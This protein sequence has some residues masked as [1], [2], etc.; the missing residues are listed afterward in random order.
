MSGLERLLQGLPLALSGV[1]RILEM[2]DW[3]EAAPFVALGQVKQRTLRRSQCSGLFGCH[4]DEWADS[5]LTALSCSVQV[6]ADQVD[7]ETDVFV[8]IAPQNVVNGTV[9]YELQDMVRAR[10]PSISPS[11]PCTDARLA[12]P[13]SCE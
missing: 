6:G 5:H 2:M 1:R 7:D 4:S 12:L 11:F 8:L 9:I 3:G 13:L 10:S